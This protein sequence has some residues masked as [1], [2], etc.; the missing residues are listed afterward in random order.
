MNTDLIEHFVRIC[1]CGSFHYVLLSGVT[2]VFFKKSSGLGFHFTI[3]LN[4]NKWLKLFSCKY[5]KGVH[6][7]DIWITCY[8]ENPVG[9]KR[10]PLKDCPGFSFEFITSS[11]SA[12]ALRGRRLL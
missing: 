7:Y 9:Q 5:L 6:S 2:K 12:A 1:F 11:G 4:V 10:S 8:G 3:C